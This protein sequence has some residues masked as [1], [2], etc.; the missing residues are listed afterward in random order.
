MKRKFVLLGLFV[1]MV[2]SSVIASDNYGSQ[3]D[4]LD[5]VPGSVTLSRGWNL[6][7]IYAFSDD[8]A[9]EGTYLDPRSGLG[10]VFFFNKYS[11]N[12]IQLFSEKDRGKLYEFFEQVG[13]PEEGGDIEEY[14]SAASSS[15]WVYASKEQ[16]L[17][18][19][20][21]DGPAPPDL[22]KL[23]SGWNFLTV[24]P[25]MV[26]DSLDNIAGDC[27][28]KKAA[29]W[30][31]GEQKWKVLNGDRGL[32]DKWLWKGFVVKVRDNCEMG[33]KAEALPDLP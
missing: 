31:S 13:D 22:M 29:Y 33:P 16:T 5:N 9:F 4:L 3:Y 25:Y 15:M 17:I 23:S 8:A 11:Q 21:L 28:I 18:F 27:E 19:E 12:Y 26:G 7:T 6:V 20:T 30:D 14:G 24:T 1:V 10:P 32:K 2:V